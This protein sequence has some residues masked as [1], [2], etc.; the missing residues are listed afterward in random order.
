MPNYK[1]GR[2]GPD[3]YFDYLVEQDEQRVR[4]EKVDSIRETIFG[5][6][7]YQSQAD[8][9][10]TQR[11][12]EFAKLVL[13]GKM[14]YSRAKAN[15]VN[16]NTAVDYEWLTTRT[17]SQLNR[18]LFLRQRFQQDASEDES[19]L[20][21]NIENIRNEPCVYLSTC[22]ELRIEPTSNRSEVLKHKSDYV[23]YF[24]KDEEDFLRK[25]A[26]ELESNPNQ[27]KDYL[28]VAAQEEIMDMRASDEWVKANGG[29]HLDNAKKYG[30]GI[31]HLDEPIRYMSKSS[32]QMFY[33]SIM[34]YM[35]ESALGPDKNHPLFDR[36]H[37]FT[38]DQ[39]AELLCRSNKWYAKDFDAA[40]D[41]VFHKDGPLFPYQFVN[42]SGMKL[43]E[44]MVRIPD[45]KLPKERSYF[46]GKFAS[47]GYI[48]PNPDTESAMKKQENGARRMPETLADIQPNPDSVANKQDDSARRMPKT[49]ADIKANPNN[50]MQLGE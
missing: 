50:G 16:K 42:H 36:P 11:Q 12:T 49:L 48:K 8:E 24:D 34:D 14:D 1:R 30:E 20:K 32:Q 22:R 41:T 21:K 3:K 26:A 46:T 18:G 43:N 40:Y 39:E 38:P 37:S 5:P 35:K 15:Y 29:V 9:E 23:A 17:D 19:V 7:S 25:K 2:M 45:D 44:Q 31:R 33:Q 4:N 27:L 13:D 28:N 47:L 10:R 6:A